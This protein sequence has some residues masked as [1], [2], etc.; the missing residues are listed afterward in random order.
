MDDIMTFPFQT[1]MRAFSTNKPIII[2]LKNGDTLGPGNIMIM[3]GQVAFRIKLKVSNDSHFVS[4]SDV[5][6]INIQ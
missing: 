5:D 3:Y 2:K 6:E 1:A 4:V